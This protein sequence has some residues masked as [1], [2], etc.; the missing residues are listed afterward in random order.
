MDES[1]YAKPTVTIVEESAGIMKS[2]TPYGS[3]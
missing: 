2:N 3:F 1:R